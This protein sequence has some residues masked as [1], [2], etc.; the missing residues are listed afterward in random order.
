M[1]S[2]QARKLIAFLLLILA[3]G[4]AVRWW[5]GRLVMDENA[6]FDVPAVEESL[7]DMPPIDQPRE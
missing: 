1:L 4:W 5:R 2:I 7:G 6:A 3:L